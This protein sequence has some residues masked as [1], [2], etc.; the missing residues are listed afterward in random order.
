[1]AD[2]FPAE[3]EV[4]LRSGSSRCGIP[5]PGCRRGSVRVPWGASVRPAP[6]REAAVVRR[7]RLHRHRA[8]PKRVRRG[9]MSSRASEG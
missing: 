1:V 9:L 2:G 7:V 3:P 5:L 6:G 4:P 8:A